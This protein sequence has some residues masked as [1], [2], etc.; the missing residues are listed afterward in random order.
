MTG[1]IIAIAQHKGGVGKTTL[2]AHLAVTWLISGRRVAL[3]DTDPQ[4]SLAHWH[5]KREERLGRGDTGFGFA[6]LASWRVAAEVSRQAREHEIVLIDSPASPDAARAVIR[7]AD[8]VL[9]PVQPSPVDVWATVPTLQMAKEERVPALLILNRVP[10]RACLTAAM[11]DWLADFDVGLA[12]INIGNRGALAATPLGGWG[13]A[14]RATG[15]LAAE[16]ITALAAEVLDLLPS[17]V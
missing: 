10:P 13:I 14:E 1:T 8:L 7:T 17:S 2:A 16:E 5:Q 6:A 15:S 11:R 3:I 4:A 12:T 9:V